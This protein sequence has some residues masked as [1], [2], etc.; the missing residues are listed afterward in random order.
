MSRLFQQTTCLV[1]LALLNVG[2]ASAEEPSERLR[3][4]R[5]VVVA[6][7]TVKQLDS[8]LPLVMSSF[9]P[10][11]TQGNQN[12]ERDFDQLTQLIFREFE[13]NKAQFADDIAR[14]FADRYTEPELQDLIRFF[15]SPT[16]QKMVRTAPAMAQ[17]TMAIGQKFGSEIAPKVMD[18][19]KAA[20]RKRGHKI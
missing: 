2:P 7:E 8:M 6:N 18:R 16:G 5:E 17:D 20:L 19:M 12:A 13:P 9:K 4:A 14:I 10:L 1:V 11:L 15:K 3:L